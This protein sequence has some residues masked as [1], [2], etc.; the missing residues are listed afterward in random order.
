LIGTT[1]PLVASTISAQVAGNIERFMVDEGTFVE[2]GEV[3]CQLDKVLKLVDIKRAQAELK[4]AQAELT[5]L[6]AGSR[7]EEINQAKAQVDNRRAL[8][9]K[10]R[11]NKE[12][13]E[14]LFSKGMVT[15]EQKQNAHWDYQQGL[16]QLQQ[17]EAALNLAVEGARSEDVMSAKATVAIRQA[18]LEM[19]E[20]NLSKTSIIAPFHGVV[21]KKYKE[22]GE[23]VNAGEAVAELINITKVLVHTSVPEKDIGTVKQGQPVEIMFDAYP[24]QLHTGTVKEIVP[25]ADLQSRS[26][27]IKIEV[28]NKKH[29]LYAGMFARLKLITGK[30]R[31]A[32]LVPKDAVLKADDT[33]YLF[34]VKNSIAHRVKVNTGQEKEELIE[35]EGELNP[36]DKVVV[37]NNEVLR[38]KM[39]VIV[40]P[41]R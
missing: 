40:A 31:T 7:E 33:N 17:A 30:Q 29:K 28:D 27:P 18:E 38:D 26:F 8:L 32:L 16:A 11:L 9:E 6:E 15:L 1:Y 23:W 36:G 14:D 12:R 4:R 19:A 35:V 10:L 39:K 25:Q 41:G 2:E 20:E 13:M 34:V 21:V 22:V 24:G 37:T 5:K 3:I